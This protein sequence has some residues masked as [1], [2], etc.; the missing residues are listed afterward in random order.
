MRHRGHGQFVSVH[1]FLIGL[2]LGVLF[3]L[4]WIA[5]VAWVCSQ[6]GWR[7]L[8]SENGQEFPTQATRLR[9]FG[10]R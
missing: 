5:A 4:P 8:W 6:D 10:S 2:A 3:A 1:A 7:L 9:S